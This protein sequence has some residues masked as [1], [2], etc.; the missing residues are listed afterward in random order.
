MTWKKWGFNPGESYPLS[1]V[2]AALYARLKNG[3]VIDR[4]AKED[5]VQW[6][7]Q[8]SEPKLVWSPKSRGWEASAFN[9][10]CWRT[11]DGKPLIAPY[12]A[13]P[14]IRT[15]TPKAVQRTPTLTKRAIR[16]TH[17]TGVPQFA[18][19][20]CFRER[21]QRQVFSCLSADKSED[22]HAKKTS[23]PVR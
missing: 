19:R 9:R 5:M 4:K 16:A 6:M 14:V 13:D 15:K 1:D 8:I 20:G 10:N 17:P 23:N 22:C 18:K 7:E 21:R 3:D 2:V 12:E 11:V